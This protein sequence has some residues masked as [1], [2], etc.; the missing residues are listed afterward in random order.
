MVSFNAF[1]A[2]LFLSCLGGNFFFSSD[3]LGCD[4]QTRVKC[5]YA[6]ILDHANSSVFFLMFYLFIYIY[7]YGRENHI[8]CM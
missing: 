4:G 2:G 8:Y 5:T 1:G 7:I 3:F 6:G